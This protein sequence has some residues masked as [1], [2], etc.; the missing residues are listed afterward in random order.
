M[1]LAKFVGL[2]QFVSP[3]YEPITTLSEQSF[4]NK[5]DKQI[6]ENI[7]SHYTSKPSL[8]AAS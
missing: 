7:N 5:I 6:L 2:A 4:P 1:G 8:S 3:T